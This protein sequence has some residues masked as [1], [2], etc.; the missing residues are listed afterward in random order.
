M[1][2]ARYR[3]LTLAVHPSTWGF[4]WLAF[5]ALQA[6]ANAVGKGE[7]QFAHD[8]EFLYRLCSQIQA[9]CEQAKSP[10]ALH[11]E[12]DLTCRVV[13]ALLS[14]EVDENVEDDR[15]AYEKS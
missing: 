13:R 1:R 6:Y 7:E 2:K 8:V 10:A 9:R 3:S 5:A 4:G 11:E 12:M 14:P 15:A